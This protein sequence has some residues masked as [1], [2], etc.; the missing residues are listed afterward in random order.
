VNPTGSDGE[1]MAE[2]RAALTAF[3]PVPEHVL[4]AARAAI[5]S[6]EPGATPADLIADSH[7]TTGAAIG[8]AAAMRLRG[9]SR[10][11]TF[12]GADL[13]VEIEV[14]GAGRDREIVGRLSP[15]APA[16]V[17]VRHPGGELTARADRTGHFIVPRVP[18][19]LMSLVFRLPDATSIV[20]SWVR[21]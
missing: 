5:A 9:A 7:A 21:L 17:R 12:E 11:L 13:A 18:A 19:G 14:T 3:E 8:A 10:L 1:L 4:A 2:V 6:Y 16:H 15:P 20:T